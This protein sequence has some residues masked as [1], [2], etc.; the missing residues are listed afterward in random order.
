MPSVLDRLL[1]DDRRPVRSQ[2]SADSELD[3]VWVRF[4]D[5]AS[6]RLAPD[7][8]DAWIRPCRLLAVDA[9]QWRI[10]TP[11]RVLRD[12]LVQQYLDALRD[13][14]AD[15]AGGK[16]RL[17][18]IVDNAVG[19][20]GI[21][22]LKRAVARD[23]EALL[24]TRQ[25]ALEEPPEQSAARS[26]PPA[27]PGTRAA[28]CAVRHRVPAE[29]RLFPRSRASR[30]PGIRPP[31]RPARRSVARCPRGGRGGPR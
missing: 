30:R 2:L 26:T 22:E 28:S 6:R 23:L 19:S 3:S 8:L 7:V 10:A 31:Y 13:S 16:P 18:F 25:E 21:R 9:D 14:A 4:L 20:Y 1:D 24:N 5:A 27:A 15:V 12:R 17:A 11:D 29:P